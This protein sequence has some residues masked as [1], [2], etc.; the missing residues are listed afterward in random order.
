MSGRT[1]LLLFALSLALGVAATGGWSSG[2]AARGGGAPTG[3]PVVAAARLTLVPTITAVKSATLQTDLNTTSFV[4]PGDTLRYSVVVSN[5][6]GPGPGNDATGVSFS[7]V[8]NNALTLVPGSVK[9]T[10]IAVGEVY[11]V[12]GNVSISV[13]AP[14]QL[15]NDVNPRAPAPSRPPAPPPAPRAAPSP[16]TR[17]APSPTTPPPAS[18]ARTPSPTPSPT[19]TGR[20]TPP[21]SRSTWAGPTA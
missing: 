20:R 2:E 4:N 12:T 5:T 3:N 17:T 9:A 21:L 8:L 11:G 14:G 15:A 13:P 6:A 18:T 1:R 7:D 19:P 10:P 16:S